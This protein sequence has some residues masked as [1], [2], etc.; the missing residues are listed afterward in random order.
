M[1]RLDLGLTQHPLKWVLRAL[2]PGVKQL[3]HEVSHSPPTNAKV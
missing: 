3:S 1:S 2:S